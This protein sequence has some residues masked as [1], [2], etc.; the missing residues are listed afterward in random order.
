VHRSDTC[1]RHGMESWWRLKKW[2]A[3]IGLFLFLFCFLSPLGCGYSIQGSAALPVHA[4]SIGQI[5]NKT[6]EPRL[7]DK[8]QTALVQVLMNNGIALESSSEYRIEGV[9]KTYALSTLAAVAGTAV[10]YEVIIRGD[11]KLVEP[12][13]KV[14]P[15]KGGGVFI[16]PFLSGG[17][18]ED[19]M[20]RRDVAIMQALQDLST[21]LVMS[22]IYP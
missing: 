12:G 18:L 6:Y 22:L 1:G 2:Q 16:V 3:I 19:V 5:V 10:E 8:L 21:E 4:V 14:K 9:I 17:A 7:E 13:G 20:A 15:L 11:F